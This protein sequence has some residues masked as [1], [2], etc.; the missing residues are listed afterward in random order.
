MRHKKEGSSNMLLDEYPHAS[1]GALEISLKAIEVED[2]DA[3]QT[4]HFM[5]LLNS[6]DIPESYVELW[7]KK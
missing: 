4:L 6:K 3:L 5:S 1:L 2:K 7:L